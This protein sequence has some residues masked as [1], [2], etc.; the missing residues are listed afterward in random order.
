MLGR[1]RA[2]QKQHK[3]RAGMLE[4]GK[5]KGETLTVLPLPEEII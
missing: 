2:A 4:K 1:L 5:E 3:K